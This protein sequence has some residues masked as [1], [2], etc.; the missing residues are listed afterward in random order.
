MNRDRRL[1][2]MIGEVLR[3]GTIASST[4]FAA[5]LVMALAGYRTDIAAVILAAALVIL[6]ATPV[7]RVIVSTIEYARERDWM[8]V[9]LTMVVLLA[10]AASVVAA[11]GLS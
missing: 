11:Y 1:E 8:F 2:G 5:G 9:V 10:L 4:L 7:A 3:F 6:M